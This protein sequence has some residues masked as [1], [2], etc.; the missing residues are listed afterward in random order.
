MGLLALQGAACAASET[1]PLDILDAEAEGQ[2]GYL[3]EQELRNVL[4]PERRCVTLL[5]QIEVDPED[6]AFEKP[7]K[8][9]GAFYGRQEAQKLKQERG[10]SFARDGEHH[11]RVVPS[12][13]RA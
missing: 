12:R 2:I 3:I 9:I 10:W 7:T 13:P 4:G 8:P 6:P 11:R 5:T 1:L